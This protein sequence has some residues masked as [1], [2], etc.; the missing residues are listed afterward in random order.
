MRNLKKNV[1][2]WF[3]APKSPR[4]L[5]AVVSALALTA[6]AAPLRER[7]AKDT[8]ARPGIIAPAAAGELRLRATFVSCS[9]CFG[10]S[11]P[12][13]GLSLECRAAGGEWKA[14][15]LPPYFPETKD[16]RGSILGLAEDT[17]YDVRLVADG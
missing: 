9:V 2:G 8:A 13:A 14:Q 6:M 4:L 1:K 16:Y 17:A 11:A 15:P 7:S 10:A 3:Y 12:I 5:V